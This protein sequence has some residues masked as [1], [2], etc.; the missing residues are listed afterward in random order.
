VDEDEQY[1]FD[2]REL[3]SLPQESNVSVIK[4]KVGERYVWFEAK[5][6][7]YNRLAESVTWRRVVRLERSSGRLRVED[8]LTGRR[9]KH[10]IQ[11]H[12]HLNK[13][14]YETSQKS[15]GV[16]LDVSFS[17]D[18][19]IDKK[20]YYEESTISQTYG[21]LKPSKHL[22]YEFTVNIPV[23]FVT[24]IIFDSLVLS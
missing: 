23:R 17:G 19:I 3:F 7:A 12:W 4:W 18:R 22:F 1:V 9:D 11:M 14:S 15:T 20:Q 24:N 10:K 6:T 13:S 21:E 16:N 8:I 5:S 2:K